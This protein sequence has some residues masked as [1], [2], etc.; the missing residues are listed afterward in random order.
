MASALSEAALSLVVATPAMIT[1]GTTAM[2]KPASSFL[3][4]D[5]FKVQVLQSDS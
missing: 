2:A 4:T 3:V 5:S 1:D